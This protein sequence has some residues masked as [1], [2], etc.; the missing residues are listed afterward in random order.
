MIDTEPPAD[1]PSPRPADTET[2][3]AEPV[4]LSPV[5]S[6]NEPVDE[7]ADDPVPTKT[8]PAEDDTLTDDWPSNCT[9]EPEDVDPR[10]D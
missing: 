6:I 7:T 3:P 4:A 2:E 9:L 5:D 8:E 10:P 1:A